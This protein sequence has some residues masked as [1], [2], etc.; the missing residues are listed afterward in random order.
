MTTFLVLG[1]S[2]FI[3]RH[4]VDHVRR[5]GGDVVSLG[6]GAGA[7][8]RAAGAGVV[9]DVHQQFDELK[10][11]LTRLRPTYVVHAI[12]GRLDRS[13]ELLV[14]TH[15]LARVLAEEAPHCRLILVG[16]AAEYGIPAAL[17]VDETHPL[18]PIAEYGLV[19]A[20][21]SWMA[22][23]MHREG[24]LSIVLARL[25]NVIGPGQ[26]EEFFL[27]SLVG[28]VLDMR[29]G[30]RR[31]AAVGNVDA[32]RDFVD[33]R[34][35]ARALEAL[36]IHGQD[37][38]AY[39]VCSGRPVQIRDVLGKIGTRCGLAADYYESVPERRREDVP[40]IYGSNRKIAQDTSWTPTIDLDQT[41]A[42]MLAHEQAR[43]QGLLVDA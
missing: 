7:P 26:G 30:L 33:V 5:R 15:R 35:V 6:R 11:V 31:A 20:L 8:G 16:S 2:G 43:R 12:G 14:F 28:Q 25:F 36:A 27:G 9:L 17:P 32:V 10:S 22:R 3:G 29:A 37:G 23:A 18:R 41:I 1:G 21:Q 24:R 19:K 34:D 13:L 38:E 39:N 40:V 42:D 4:L